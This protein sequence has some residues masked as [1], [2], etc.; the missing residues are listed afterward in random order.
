MT[1]D[2]LKRR[3][4]MPDLAEWLGIKK[5]KGGAK[6]LWHSPNRPDKTPSLSIFKAEGTGLW[7]FKDHATGEHGSCIDLV[8]YA[9]GCGAGEAVRMIHQYLGIPL[10]QPKQEARAKTTVEYIAERCMENNAH[11]IEYLCDVRKV[12]HAIVQRALER[13]SIGF[14]TWTSP[15]VAAGEVGHGGRA[16]AF[17]VRSPNPNHVVAVDMRYLDPG[18][19]G[20]VKTQ[21]QGEKQGYPWTSDWRRVKDAKTLFV[22]EGAVDALSAEAAEIPY[23][24]AIATRGTATVEGIDWRFAQ[25]KQVVISMSKDEPFK[26]GKL[27]GYCAGALA[28]WKLHELLTSLDIS[29]ILV[30]QEDWTVK[31]LNEM[32]QKDGAERVNVALNKLESWLIAGKP[33]IQEDKEDKRVRGRARVFLPFH[34]HVAYS[35]YRVKPDFTNGVK[36]VKDEATGEEREVF[37][38]IA[39]FRIASLSRVTIASAVSTMT[40]DPDSQPKVMFAVS[41]QAPRHG[42]KLIRRVLEDDKLH[43]V[44]VWK[45]FGPVFSQGPFQRMVNILERTADIGERKAANFVGLAWRDSRLIVN[46]G[47]NCYF[48]SPEQ[49][50]PYY[51]LSFPSGTLQDARTVIEAYQRTFHHNAASL[52]LVWA[53]GGHLK[54]LLGFWP[55]MMMQAEK[56]SG[57][58][59][60]TKQLERT[61]AMTMFSGQSLQTE[62]R[63]LTSLAHTSHAVGWEEL[64]ARHQQV[65]DKAVSLLQEAYQYTVTRRGAELTEYLVSAPVLLAGEDVPIKSLFGKVIRTDLS[66]RMGPPLPIDLPRFPVRQW[67]EFLTGLTRKQMI[68]RYEASKLAYAK[69]SMASGRDNG[70]SRMAGNY[71]AVGLAWELLCEFAEIDTKA[72]KFLDDLQAEMN[73]FIK[74]TSGDREPWVWIVETLLS[75]IATG[76][77]RHPYTWDKVRDPDQADADNEDCLLVRT[78][79]VMDHL[80]HTSS[81]RDKWNSLPIKSDRVFK[82]TLK[83]AGVVVRDD[84]ERA[85][86]A[87]GYNNLPGK[88]V[89]H[90]T[91]LSIARMRKFGLYVVGPAD[92]V[93]EAEESPAA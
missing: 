65:I 73:A 32:L 49:Q 40:G 81:L 52:V 43:N 93:P 56:G 58:S 8:M 1:I 12:P 50:C 63:L 21:T 3:V 71:A 87:D 57:K 68:E 62:F 45:K 51:N 53:L 88:R 72:G 27:A 20:G 34:D 14:N 67:L 83:S 85:I 17:I 25:G 69:K 31:D 47:P 66:E 39:G 55:H 75:E 41:V 74:E 59:T 84:V 82:K 90:L 18:L 16:A 80:A 38:E 26:D 2:E 48:T 78:S 70:A 91:A 89:S 28:A 30:D 4:E 76:N 92:K 19:N 54:A 46:E 22:V 61:L 15:K 10:E 42:P 79:H 11:A 33:V 5:A 37:S 6:T 44:E 35:R 29:A 23:S 13:R 36:K 7:T 24:A 77:F 9:R 64:S 60:L 86:G